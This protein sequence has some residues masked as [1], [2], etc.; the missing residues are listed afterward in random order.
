[1]SSL[2]QGCPPGRWPRA[3]LLAPLV[4]HTWWHEPWAL[5]ALPPRVQDKRGEKMEASR[6][7]AFMGDI[8]GVGA[9]AGGRLAPMMPTNCGTVLRPRR[10]REVWGRASMQGEGDDQR[11]FEM[12]SLR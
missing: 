7:V 1:M 5:E 3:C 10:T 6:G 4:V 2:M 8:R 9:V 12:R 11:W